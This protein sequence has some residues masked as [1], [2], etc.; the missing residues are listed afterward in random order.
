VNGLRSLPRDWLAAAG[1]IGRFVAL[2]AGDV[3]RGR[4]L[5]FFGEPPNP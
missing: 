4:V 3:Y 2:V 1:E 5:R